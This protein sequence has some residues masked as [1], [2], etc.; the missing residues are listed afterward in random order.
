MVFEVETLKPYHIAL[1]VSQT[2]MQFHKKEEI[3]TDDQ[4]VT[5]YVISDCGVAKGEFAK[6][7]NKRKHRDNQ[8]YVTVEFQ[9]NGFDM[10]QSLQKVQQINKKVIP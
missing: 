6:A 5:C 2:I 3:G 1:S 4:H 9:M 10:V 7:G 8:E